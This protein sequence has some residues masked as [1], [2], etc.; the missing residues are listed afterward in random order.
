MSN[1]FTNLS[2]GILAGGKST[3]MGQNKALLQLNNQTII[4]RLTE[5]LGDIK[6]PIIS[7]AELILF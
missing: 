6:T 5:E 7:C 2:I 3:R 4:E 1:K